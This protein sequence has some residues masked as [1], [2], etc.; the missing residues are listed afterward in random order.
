M[1]KTFTISV[2]DQLW[3]DTWSTN[4]TE[5]YIYSG[6]NTLYV[7]INDFTDAVSYWSEEPIDLPTGSTDFV[8]ELDATN[9]DNVPVAHFLHSQGIEHEYT[10]EDETNHDGSVYQKITNPVIQ[11]YFDIKYDRG[12]GLYL[13]P[14][15]KTT[16]TI[17]EEKAEKR[18]EYVKKYNNAYDFDEDTQATI[19]KFLT[20]MNT[21]LTTMST[22]YPWKYESI[23]E[24][25]IPKIPASLVTVFNAL[26]EVD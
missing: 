7:L 1:S 4:K 18:L 20:D 17:A 21:Y 6:P 14:M 22:V 15:Y 2:P 13:E 8:V 3:V 16:K 5:S 12:N 11:D 25:D 26:P 9:D 19:D 24:S 23:D 10:Y